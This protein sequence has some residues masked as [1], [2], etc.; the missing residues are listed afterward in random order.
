[1][2]VNLPD[3]V[4]IWLYVITAVGTPVIG[5]LTEQGFLPSWAMTLWTAEVA[6]I[7]AMAALNVATPSDK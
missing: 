4:R 5:V 2:R 3:K 7:G 6:V 1:M